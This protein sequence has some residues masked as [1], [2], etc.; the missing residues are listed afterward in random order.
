VSASRRPGDKEIDAMNATVVACC[1]L[2]PVLGDPA[3]NREL[4]AEA[5]THAAAQGARVVVLPELI[6]SGYVFETRDEA[7]ACAEAPDGETVTSWRRLSAERGLVIVGGFCERAAGQ[8]YNSA[9]VVDH[10]SLRCVYRKAHLWDRERLWFSP[11]DA[12]PPVVAT[13][14]GRIGVMLCYDLECPEWV[15]LPALDGAQLLCAPVNWPAAPHPDGERPAEIM[16]AQADAAV[17]RMFVAV[18]DR[19]GTERGADWV[20]GSIIIDPDGWPL[21]VAGRGAG[22]VT[23]TAACRLDDAVSKDVSPLSNVHRDRRPELYQ[24]V[25]EPVSPAVPSGSSPA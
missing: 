21:A 25:A 20:S 11:G 6:S 3:S 19:T 22:P 17:N 5:V 13:P 16:K 18:C 12:A 10:G 23:I 4:T 1:Q 9:A 2:A 24:R 14:F 15:R 7:S 8:A